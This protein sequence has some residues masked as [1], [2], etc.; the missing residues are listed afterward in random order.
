M[1]ILDPRHEHVLGEFAAS[2]TLLAFDYDGTL[3][4]IAATPELAHMRKGTHDLFVRVARCYPS[5]V[6]SGRPLDELTRRLT[7]IHLR[8][9]FGNFGVEPPLGATRPRRLSTWVSHLKEQLAEHQGLVVEDKRYSVTIH[10]RHALDERRALAAIHAAAGTVPGVRI[11]GGEQAVTL[12]PRE[13]PHKG[14]ALLEAR[15]MLAC[16]KTVYVGDDDADEDAFRSGDGHELLSIRVGASPTS[17]AR[18]HLAGQA[19]VDALLQAL[20]ALRR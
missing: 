11:L 1:N 10:Y 17:S 14:M 2:N 12:L 3:V 13:G 18:Y 4:P 20:L 6:I 16:D 9:L 5:V 8:L 19:D 15:R 7:G